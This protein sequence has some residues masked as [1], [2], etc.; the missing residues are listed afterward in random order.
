MWVTINTDASYHPIHKVGA[1]AFWIVSNQGRIMKSGPL[2]EA[3]NSCDAEAKCIANALHTL[4]KSDWVG[5][6]RVLI[7]TDS[8]N[9][10]D[11]MSGIARQKKVHQKMHAILKQ[12]RLKYKS[13]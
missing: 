10:I 1:Y 12:L 11:A 6:T 13:K 2:R 8:K 4:L 5:V 3:R 7:N 9:T